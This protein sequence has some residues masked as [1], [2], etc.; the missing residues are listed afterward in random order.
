MN[1]IDW[2][3]L[4]KYSEQEI[5]YAHSGINRIFAKAIMDLKERQEKHT[6]QLV[7]K[8]VKKALKEI[9]DMDNF[10]DGR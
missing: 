9:K 1:N 2:S 7:I 5:N 3:L 4:K 6:H 8:E 10:D